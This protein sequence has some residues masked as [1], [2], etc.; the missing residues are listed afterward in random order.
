MIYSSSPIGLLLHRPTGWLR[1]T[2]VLRPA[3]TQKRHRYRRPGTDGFHAFLLHGTYPWILSLLPAVTP[4]RLVTANPDGT[5]STP[6]S[7]MVR[8]FRRGATA[9]QPGLC[10]V[11]YSNFIYALFYLY[12]FAIM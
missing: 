4:K 1:L 3:V 12:T 6:F 5:A 7:R 8:I 9:V 2:R 10:A 11:L